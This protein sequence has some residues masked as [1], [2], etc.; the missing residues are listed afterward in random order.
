MWCIHF[1]LFPTLLQ[2]MIF[3]LQQPSGCDPHIHFAEWCRGISVTWESDC[4]TFLL[5]R[6]PSFTGFPRLCNIWPPSPLL[7]HPDL[8]VVAYICPQPLWLAP[9]WPSNLLFSAWDFLTLLLSL[10]NLSI[11]FIF[12]FSDPYH[13][14]RKVIPDPSG[15]SSEPLNVQFF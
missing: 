11:S 5:L 7:L 2:A 8:A 1:Y 12:H 6:Q 15:P 14:S 9:S 13:T 3:Y 10:L 4:V